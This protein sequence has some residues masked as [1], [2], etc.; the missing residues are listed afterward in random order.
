M[1]RYWK[2]ILLGGF[3]AVILLYCLL[4]IITGL[5]LRSTLD[6]MQA[7][8]LPMTLEEIVAPTPDDADNAA[9][10]LKQAFLGFSEGEAEQFTFAQ[11]V[12][13][14]TD[15]ALFTG[16]ESI[17]F[18]D[19]AQR[20]VLAEALQQPIF[21]D[22]MAL[23][24]QAAEL[25][26][27]DFGLD[28]SLGPALLLPHLSPIRNVVRLLG[29]RSALRSTEGDLS[30]ALA[31]VERMLRISSH[32]QHEPIIISYLV[33]VACDSISV[34]CLSGIAAQSDCPLPEAE[35]A[36]VIA[37]LERHRTQARLLAENA[38]DGERILLG[39]WCFEGLLS[40]NQEL[41]E[42]AMAGDGQVALL[43]KLPIKPLFKV[44]YNAY[45]KIMRQYRENA[46][47]PY[48]EL[49]GARDI[50]MPPRYCLFT[51]MIAPALGSASQRIAL[52]KSALQIAQVGLRLQAYRH[53]NGAYPQTLTPLG[54]DILDPTTD[55]PYLY[56]ASDGDYQLYSLGIDGVRDEGRG[57]K[58]D[59][60]WRVAKDMD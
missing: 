39:T 43:A 48:T 47:L 12:T 11:V 24:E 13:D 2:I 27:C 5:M 32:L 25:P 35:T 55:K 4:N 37:E 54:D 38:Y 22:N 10:P 30:G 14:V 52:H 50:E 34:A 26:A 16:E 28:Y 21:V 8:G 6:E 20:A 9:I 40:G 49:A 18:L 44:D 60:I 59:V 15:K 56:S 1:N 41:L 51:H 7:A 3:I 36:G 33:L 57:R 42:E 58:D 19:D 31:D 29:L 46:S 17:F 45:L 53:A 23:L